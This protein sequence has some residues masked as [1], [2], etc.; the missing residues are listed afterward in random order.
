M[1]EYLRNLGLACA[2]LTV[3][4]TA[5]EAAVH[6]NAFLTSTVNTTGFVVTD[7]AAV[8][9]DYSAIGLMQYSTIATFL[10]TDIIAGGDVLIINDLNGIWDGIEFASAD[11]S[12]FVSLVTT[13]TSLFDGLDVAQL[14]GFSFNSASWDVMNVFGLNGTPVGSILSDFG[15]STSVTSAVP[16]PAGLPLLLGGLAAFGF[17]A[18]RRGA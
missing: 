10:D 6:T 11:R 9:E 5:A 17:A 1:Y 16:I 7:N 15:R 18:R 2:A 4:G 14:T 13:D 12:Y 3:V 8:T